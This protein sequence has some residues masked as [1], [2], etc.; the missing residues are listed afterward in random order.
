V[1]PYKKEKFFGIMDLEQNDKLHAIWRSAILMLILIKLIEF[2]DKW[3]WRSLEFIILIPM[4][5]ETSQLQKIKKE[6]IPVLT[7]FI[8]T[9]MKEKFGVPLSMFKSVFFI[10]I[11]F[12]FEILDSR[13][14]LLVILVYFAAGIIWGITTIIPDEMKSNDETTN[15]F[16]DNIRDMFGA[17]KRSGR[18]KRRGK[19][20]SHSVLKNMEQSMI[21]S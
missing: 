8:Q 17:E 13:L 11:A 20:R 7:L 12:L 14:W 4:I 16:S 9:E 2:E 21:L 18:R 6:E 1:R 5:F 3:Y 15:D 10:M 19:K